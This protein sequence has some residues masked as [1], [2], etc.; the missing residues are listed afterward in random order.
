MQHLP[1]TQSFFQA[2]DADLPGTKRFDGGRAR[3]S[4]EWMGKE[5]TSGLCARKNISEN[6]DITPCEHMLDNCPRC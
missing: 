3:I 2:T 5:S 6:G 1:I 4:P